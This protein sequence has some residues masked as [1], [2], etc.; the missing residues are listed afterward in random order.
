[1]N[2]DEM[3]KDKEQIARIIA[4]EL[5]PQRYHKELYGE[6]AK[7]YSD[8]NFGDC[9]KIKAVVD[10]L[11]NAGYRKVADDEI[12]IKKRQYEQLKKYNRDRKRLR[13]K[14]QQAKQALEQERKSC[15]LIADDEIVESMKT[16]ERARYATAREILQFIDSRLDIRR[17]GIFGLENEFDN[18]YKMAIQDIKR[19]IKNKYGIESED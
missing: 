3:I 6:N 8:N 14:W 15:R 16:Y 2:K 1:M 9:K 13:L 5:C 4:F 12:V 10:K 11:Y 17:H 7:C 18:G 19:L